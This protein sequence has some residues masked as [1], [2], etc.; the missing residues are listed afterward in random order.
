M[1]FFRCAIFIFMETYFTTFKR[2]A[3]KRVRE[4]RMQTQ[5]A[6][7]KRTA[8]EKYHDTLIP[9]VEL[10][11]KRRVMDTDY[12]ACLH[13]ENME[14]IQADPIEAITTTGVRTNSGREVHADAVIF[15]TGFKATQ[16]LYPLEIRGE[17]GISMTDHVCTPLP[18]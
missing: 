7:L 10:G 9:K 11:C 12:F 17:N 6:Y 13:R 3:G 1:R 2:V 16:P 5:T 14:L 15:A 8:P 18:L 4:K